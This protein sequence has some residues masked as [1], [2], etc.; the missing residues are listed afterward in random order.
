MIVDLSILCSRFDRFRLNY[1]HMHVF[2]REDFGTGPFYWIEVGFWKIWM[3]L[4]RGAV[5]I[6]GDI[7][8]AVGSEETVVPPEGAVV[9]EFNY[10][11]K[12]FTQRELRHFLGYQ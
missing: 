4:E 6:Q 3:S 2:S 11:N 9:Q 7:I 10:E 5:L 12:T 1:S 8:K